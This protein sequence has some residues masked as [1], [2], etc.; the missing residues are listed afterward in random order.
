MKIYTKTGDNGSTGLVSGERISK[1]SIRIESYGTV[2]ELNSYLGIVIEYISDKKWKSFF[3]AIQNQLFIIGSH[4]AAGSTNTYPLPE[5]KGEYIEAL[6]KAIDTLDLELPPLKFFI[7]PGGHISVAQ[8]HVAR[9]ICRRGERNIVT[10]SEIEAVDLKIIKYM[11][12]LSDFLFTFARYLAKL[13]EIEE[14]AW[15]ADV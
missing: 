15:K 5:M 7:L 8:C 11:N 4:L 3:D 14:K 12:R 1:G 9:C 6:E 2:D 13:N 10:L